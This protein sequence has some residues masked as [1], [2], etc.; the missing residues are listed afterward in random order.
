MEP[1]CSRDKFN[2]IKLIRQYKC[3]V[4]N[5]I[6]KEQLTTNESYKNLKELYNKTQNNIIDQDSFLSLLGENF[7]ADCPEVDSEMDRGNVCEDN[8][9]IEEESC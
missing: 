1:E 4:Y 5:L 2:L 3:L 8:Q 6:E 7:E 9:V